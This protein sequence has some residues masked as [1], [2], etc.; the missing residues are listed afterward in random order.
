MDL[1]G[2][3]RD[4]IYAFTHAVIYAADFNIRP[5]SFPR[6]RQVL[7]GEA[8]AALARAVDAE[9]YD[10]CGELLMTWPLTG[11]TWSAASAFGF[12]VLAD[13]EDQVG[14]L[15][16]AAT[17]LDRLNALDGA[18]RAE[19]LTA[20]AYHTAYVM[21]LLC[22]AALAPGREPPRH[23]PFQDA[24]PRPAAAILPFFDDGGRRRHWQDTFDRFPPMDRDAL[25]GFLLTIA[26][27]RRVAT[28][29][30]AA[31]AKLLAIAV[32]LDLA[33]MPAA[34]Q[35]AELLGRLSV[36]A[37]PRRRRA[38]PAHP[39]TGGPGP[40]PPAPG[41]INGQ[42][43]PEPANPQALR[44]RQRSRPRSRRAPSGSALSPVAP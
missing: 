41:R 38:A 26:L 20:T 9:D 37:S 39:D 6:P 27:H 31:V 11:T 17:R 13:V 22:A 12:K 32:S 40:R 21:G 28:Y 8:E 14:F 10:I 18:A 7:L 25:S 16:T 23:L 24:V 33:D 1:F 3:T 30:F 19:Y 5:A 2:G 44:G 36:A 15:P 29:D 42:E 43:E 34:S 35:A 4:D